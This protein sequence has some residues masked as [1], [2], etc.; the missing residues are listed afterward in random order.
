MKRHRR[1]LA[2]LL[3]LALALPLSAHADAPESTTQIQNDLRDG[4]AAGS[5]T[6]Q[7]IRNFAV[8]MFNPYPAAVSAAGTTQG[9]A[10]VL[11]AMFNVITACTSG[12]G[13]MATSYYTKIWNATTSACL[14]YPVSGAQFDAHGTNAA[15]YIAGGGSAEFIMTS[16]TQ[17]YAR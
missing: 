14:V 6:P 10:T 17:G 4:Q 13:V 7:V 1:L 8:S 5:I 12:Q 16:A 9:T 3:G 2:H 15:V 11:T